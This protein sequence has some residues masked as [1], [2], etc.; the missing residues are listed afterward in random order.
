MKFPSFIL[1]ILSEILVLVGCHDSPTQ[2]V[3]SN[4]IWV[5]TDRLTYKFSNSTTRDTVFMTFHNDTDTLMLSWYPSE[6]WRWED[7][8]KY[9]V[10]AADGRCSSIAPHSQATLRWYFMEYNSMWSFPNGLYK[11]GVEYIMDTSVT[12]RFS[13]QI[14]YSDTLFFGH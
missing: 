10:T 6:L 8:L 12:R 11:I 4:R 1:F 7:T 3:P 9:L 5:S 13:S 2:N 14:V